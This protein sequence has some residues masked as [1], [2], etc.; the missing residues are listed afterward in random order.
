MPVKRRLLREEVTYSQVASKEENILHK[1]AYWDKQC[2]FFTYI[3]RRRGL[4]ESAVAHH[5]G[6]SSS[7]RCQAADV[8]D[9]MRGSF[10]LCVP[11]TIDSR[12][13]RRRRVLMRF[14]LQ[15]RVGE[16][17]R[18][19]NADEKVRCEAGAYAWLG[20]EC[21]SIPMPHM[22]GFALAGGQRFT[23]LQHLSLSARLWQKLR[24][25]ARSLLQLP[26]PSP[27]VPHPAK[28]DPKNELGPYLLLDFIDESQGE[29]LSNTW[30]EKYT[31]K[32]LRTNFFRNLSKIMVTLSRK[33]LPKIGSFIIDDDGILC[34]ENR[35]LTVELQVLENEHIPLDNVIPR[36]QTFHGV[37]S[38]VNRLLSM[39]DTRLRHQPNAVNNIADCAGQM[40]AL[41]MMRTVAHEFF[42]CDLNHG[43]FIYMLTDLHASNIFVDEYW[44]IKFLIDLEWAASLPLEFMQ[45]P[46]WLTNEQCDVIDATRYNELREEFTE[47]LEEEEREEEGGGGDTKIRVEQKKEESVHR[48]ENEN[49]NMCARLRLSTVMKKTWDRGAFWYILALRSPT[50]LNTLFYDRIQPLYALGHANEGQFYLITHRYWTRGADSIV[51]QKVADK[52]VYDRKLRKEF[53]EDEDEEGNVPPDAG[54][55][56]NGNVS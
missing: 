38:Y 14:P 45:P 54:G 56:G 7:S 2:E 51:R 6:L 55:S 5:M 50:G 17:F 23:T 8:K 53:G 37:D 39:H 11:V 27:L 46:S 35:P 26:L 40:S 4:I 47:I 48:H 22:Y 18:P 13:T 24:Y 3:H 20:R 1:L 49:E 43:P 16:Q 12:D 42:D 33:P 34:L 15:H 36:Q 21:P 32:S 9:W 41:A 25:W 29:M 31:D 44:N 10:N 28:F 19:G 30:S 52:E